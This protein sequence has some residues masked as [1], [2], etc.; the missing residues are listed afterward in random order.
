MAI[1][2]FAVGDVLTAADTNTYLANAG[3]VVVTPS[4]ATNGTVS[5]AKVTIGTTVSSV[6]VSGVFSSTYDAYRVVISG[7]V[8]S[9]TNVLQLTLGA[10]AT[11]YYY[12][13]KGRTYAGVD[14]N[15]GSQNTTNYY[16][17][18]GSTNALT[19]DCTIISPNLAKNTQFSSTV[20]AARTDG[21][22][23]A[24][25]GYLADTTQYT[26]FT[27]TA[28]TGTITGGTI[29]VYGYRLG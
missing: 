11:G 6:T 24:I 7:G 29:M 5:G 20:S 14:V 23:L 21:Y 15:L 3:L 9:A 12:A 4:G 1:K 13:G 19:L 18:E 8:A 27:L 17:G 28:S 2:T 16:A 26:A 22:Q 25:A 10:T